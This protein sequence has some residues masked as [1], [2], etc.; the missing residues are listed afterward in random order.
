MNRIQKISWLIAVTHT[1]AIICSA[2]AVA[3]LYQR[4]GFPKAW[5]G[6]AFMAIAGIGGLGPIIFGK[7]P[8]PVQTDERDRLILIKAARGSFALSYLVFGLMCMGTWWHYHA[9]AVETISIHILPW[10]FG[11]AAVTAFLSHA[12]TI[13]VLYGREAKSSQ[14]DGEES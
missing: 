5:A 6:L 10:I 9:K 11:A 7:D 8:G 3:L 2:I 12:I 1:I 4:H 13:L 14:L